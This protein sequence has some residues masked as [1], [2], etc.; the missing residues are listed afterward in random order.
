MCVHFKVIVGVIILKVFAVFV[1]FSRS[2]RII[3]APADFG[4]CSRI[5]LSA[6]AALCTDF[7]L[8]PAEISAIV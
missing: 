5:V 4:S 6:H 7:E 1:I 8:E 3:A 2:L